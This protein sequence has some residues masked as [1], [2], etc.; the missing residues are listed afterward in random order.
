MDGDIY[1]QFGEAIDRRLGRVRAEAQRRAAAG[2]PPPAMFRLWQ[3]KEEP[4]F[5]VE[6]VRN[7]EE[8][9]QGLRGGSETEETIIIESDDEE[10]EEKTEPPSVLF[11]KMKDLLDKMGRYQQKLVGLCKEVK[12]WRSNIPTVF[13]YDSGPE[14]A[15][16]RP[17]VNVVG[18]CP[19]PGIRGRPLT[20][21]ARLA[22]AARTRNQ[23]KA[24][25]SQEPPRGEHEPGRRKEAV[26]V[27][28]D[29]DEEE[30]DERLRR[31]EDQRAEQRARK[32][33][34]RGEA[35]PVIHDGPPKK[36][37][38]AVRLEEGFDVE[39]VID[40]LLE[41]HNDLMT[42][43]EILASAPRLHDELKGRLSRRLVPNVHL[44][45][46]LPKEAEW[47]E[48]STKMDWKCVACGTVD[49]M[50][51]GSKCAAMVDTEAEMNIIREADAIHY[52]MVRF[53]L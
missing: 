15:P 23:A 17:G 33:G 52:Q 44:G 26:E 39:K 3:E 36:K 25:T 30:E 4:P 20:P 12:G 48:S 1:D 24:S 8:V 9:T 19:Q 7:D 53:L 31:E 11:E 45:T 42:L 34:A 51:K 6:E 38:Y 37:K 50:V 32:K 2:P 10:E 14:S 21:Q 35:E 40:R 18:S 13:L 41:G 5:G 22:Q 46:I 28:D 29:D 27:E 16:G 49:F 43:K 47:A